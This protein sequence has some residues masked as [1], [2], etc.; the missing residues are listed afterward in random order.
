MGH[1]GD[2]GMIEPNQTGLNYWIID[3]LG[4]DVCTKKVKWKYAESI[5]LVNDKYGQPPTR[6]FICRSFVGM[7]LYLSRHFLPGIDYLVNYA[8]IY[9]FFTKHSHEL[10]SKKMSW[11][12]RATRDRGLLINIST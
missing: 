10:A 12:L 5:P 4:L 3:Y 7:L 11:Y 1:D 8:D 9:M 6:Y 2:T